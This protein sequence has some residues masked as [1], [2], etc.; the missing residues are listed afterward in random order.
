MW[1]F[2]PA[3]NFQGDFCRWWSGK[4]SNREV[5]EEAGVKICMEV[6]FGFGLVFS[7]SRKSYKFGIPAQG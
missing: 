3:R 6:D 4:I 7:F 5:L 2:W 1:N